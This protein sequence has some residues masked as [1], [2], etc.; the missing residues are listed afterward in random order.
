MKTLKKYSGKLILMLVGGGCGILTGMELVAMN[1]VELPF[2]QYLW[3]LSGMVC[4]LYLAFFLQLILH[5]AGHLLCGLCTGYQFSSFR[6]GSFLWIRQDGKLRLKRFHLAGTGG[7]CL[8]LPPSLVDG[9]LPYVLYNLGG[10]LANLLAA[11]LCFGLML[12]VDHGLLHFFLLMMAATGVGYA[13]VNGIPMES[14]GVCNDGYNARSLGKNPN[15]LRAFWIQMKINE[16]QA[17]GV[18]LRDMPAEWFE[19]PAREDMSN[20]MCAAVAV[21]RTNYL[22]DRQEFTQAAQSI[23]ILLPGAKT[24]EFQI[25]GLYQHMMACDRIFCALVCE[26]DRETVAELLTKEQQAAMNQMKQMLTVIRTRYVL[27]LLYHN[28]PEEAARLQTLFDKQ[29]A[30]YPHPAEV[31]GERALM[32]LAK[33]RSAG[34]HNI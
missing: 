3:M 22:M 29:A 13:L 8:L 31:D 33:E 25:Q 30:R 23:D 34:L 4:L 14:G 12:S 24:G 28:D 17:A 27:A 2:G 15:A 9:K 26:G 21:I 19:P 16:A 6:V 20:S 10:S 7:Q 5:E 11:A 32:A 18:P 1:A